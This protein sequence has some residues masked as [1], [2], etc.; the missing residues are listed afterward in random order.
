MQQ[1]GKTAL[2]VGASSGIGKAIAE[3]LLAAG[4]TV[5]LTSR[6]LENLAPLLSKWGQ[7]A[8]AKVI[9]VDDAEAARM[10][11]RAFADDLGGVDL[12]VLNA[13]TGILNRDFSWEPERQTIATNVLGF[14]AMTDAAVHHCIARGAGRIVGISSV[15]KKRGHPLT[16][17]YSGSKAF[18]SLYLDGVRQF[19]RRKAPKVSVTEVAPGYIDTPLQQFDE[20]FWVASADTAARQIIAAA[21]AGRKHA[22]VP[23][24]WGLIAALLSLMPR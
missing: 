19:V 13:G 3:Q 11:L 5:G 15:A 23:R 6:K 9:D 1:L 2:V 21:L 17:S 16:A 24:R 14:A 18:V 8:R 20:A 7:Q 10:G 12:W 22:Y 4:W